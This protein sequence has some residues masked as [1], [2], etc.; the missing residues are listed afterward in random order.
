MC[1]IVEAT[2]RIITSNFEMLKFFVNLSQL[3]ASLHLIGG[4][5]NFEVHFTFENSAARMNIFQLSIII[6]C[7]V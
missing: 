2:P 5:K 3:E 7:I 4:G 1:R 6:L